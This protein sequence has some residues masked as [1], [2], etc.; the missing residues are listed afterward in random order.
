MKVKTQGP[1]SLGFVRLY[2]L[3]CLFFSANSVLTVI[4]PLKSE[5]EGIGQ[6]EIG[7]CLCICNQLIKAMPGFIL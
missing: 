7:V 2:M 6:A 4:L 5:E 3:A 1:L